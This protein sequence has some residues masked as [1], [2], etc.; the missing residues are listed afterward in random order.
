VVAARA[1]SSFFIRVVTDAIQGKASA[2]KMLL[3]LMAR[4]VPTTADAAHAGNAED[5]VAMLFDK[6]DLM[7]KRRREMPG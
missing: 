1:S 4:F 5:S 3:A 7:A 6:I 2:Q